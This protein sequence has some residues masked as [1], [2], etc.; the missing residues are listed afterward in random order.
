MIHVAGPRNLG[1]IQL[2]S[3]RIQI[4]SYFDEDDTRIEDDYQPS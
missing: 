1:K 2:K 4:G 3:I